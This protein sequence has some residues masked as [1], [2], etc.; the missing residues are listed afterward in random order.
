MFMNLPLTIQLTNF[1][2]YWPFNSNHLL[3]LVRHFFA[4]GYDTAKHPFIAHGKSAT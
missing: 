3:F 1:S 2:L 4:L